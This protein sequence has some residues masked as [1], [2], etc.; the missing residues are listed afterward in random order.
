MAVRSSAQSRN[1]ARKQRDKWKAKRLYSIRA[2]RNP[3]QYKKIG[4]TIGEK[5]RVEREKRKPLNS[6]HSSVHSSHR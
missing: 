5:R 2:P 6:V 1:L 3:W 4:E